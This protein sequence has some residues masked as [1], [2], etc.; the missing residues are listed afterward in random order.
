MSKSR[1]IKKYFQVVSERK[2]LGFPK[3]TIKSVASWWWVNVHDDLCTKDYKMPE[4]VRDFPPVTMQ[5]SY[6]ELKISQQYQ[7][8]PK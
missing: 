7:N 3:R 8:E 2:K 5:N 1:F 6:D 4:W